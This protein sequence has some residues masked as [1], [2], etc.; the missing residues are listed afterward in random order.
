MSDII[1]KAKF[2]KHIKSI[3]VPQGFV[4]SMEDDR[5]YG[6]PEYDPHTQVF[7]LK[8]DSIELRFD[9]SGCGHT[10]FTHKGS[11]LCFDR[12]GIEDSFYHLPMLD[13]DDVPD[14]NAIVTEQIERVAEYLKIADDFIQVPDLPFTVTPKRLAELK[15]RLRNNNS[16]TFRP[17][18]FGIGYVL[19]RHRTDR[20]DK[21]STSKTEDFFGVGPLFIST[22]DAD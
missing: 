7:V 15:T 21:R 4:A 18:G 17:S 14:V 9:Q 20:N 3:T 12:R 13:G 19:A 1:S 16:I 6:N 11:Q 8:S 5:W 10:L 2:A 22:F